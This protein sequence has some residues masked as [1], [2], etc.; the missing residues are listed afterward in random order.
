LAVE[1]RLLGSD[2]PA[3]RVWGSDPLL[4]SK[5]A[6]WVPSADRIWIRTGW[7]GCF[8]V[9][10]ARRIGPDGGWQVE[11]IAVSDAFGLHLL[12]GR[13][14]SGSDLMISSTQDGESTVWRIGGDPSEQRPVARLAGLAAGSVWLDPPGTLAVNLHRPGQPPSGFLVDL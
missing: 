11:R 14:R 8:R 7:P 4:T 3:E 13:E 6:L 9:L 10:E 1:A 5:A 2:A 12:P